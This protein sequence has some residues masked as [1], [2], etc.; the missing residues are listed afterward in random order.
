MNDMLISG[1]GC[2]GRYFSVITDAPCEHDTSFAG[3]RCFY[4]IDESYGLCVGFCPASVVSDD[5]FD[6]DA[7]KGRCNSNLPLVSTTSSKSV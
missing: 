2:C 6:R 1:S 4:R 7:C 3:E 5:G